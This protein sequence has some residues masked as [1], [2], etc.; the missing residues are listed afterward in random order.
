[1][2]T[3]PNRNII[4]LDLDTFFVSVERRINPKLI[5]KPVLVGGNGDRGV[6][7][8]CSY[9]ARKFGIRSAMPMKAALRLCS[10]AVVV[11]GDYEAYSKYSNLVTDVIRDRV[12]LFE[13]SSIDEFYVDMTGMEKFFGCSLYSKELK[14]AIYQE[15]GLPISYAL[16]SNK[17]IGKVATN[18]VKPNGQLEIPFGNERSYLAPLKV[19]RLPGVGDKTKILLINMGIHKIETLAQIPIPLMIN[20][21][22]KPGIDLHRKANGIDE[23]PVVPFHEAKSISTEH[24]FQQDTIDLKFLHAELSRMTEKIAFQLRSEN[25][26]T[27]C[28]AVKIRYSDFDTISVQKSIAYCNQDHVILSVV[29]ELFT[30]GNTRRL[31]IRLIGVRF[32]NLIPGN[33]QINLFQDSAAKISLYQRIDSIKRQFGENFVQKASGFDNRKTK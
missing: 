14:E 21:L 16:A 19:D 6:V 24:T 3:E 26:L 7:A 22:G 5:G 10:H 30:K 2:P 27:G 32:S 4:H 8:S 15:S 29:K 17:L 18:E 28:V 20:L 23:S 25:K 33:Y 12:P 11:R 9:E 13:K 1:M 31:L